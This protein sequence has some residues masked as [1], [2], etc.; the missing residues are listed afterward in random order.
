MRTVRYAAAVS[1]ARSAGAVVHAMWGWPCN[2]RLT[3]P[4]AKPN[5]PSETV[6][7]ATARGRRGGGGASAFLC[8]VASFNRA[9]LLVAAVPLAA[10]PLTA[11]PLAAFWLTVPLAAV[12]LAAGPLAAGPLTAVPLPTGPLAAPPGELVP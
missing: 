8:W 10:G 7:T 9:S 5:A 6:I 2:A 4:M 3:P 12:P 11:V 1:N